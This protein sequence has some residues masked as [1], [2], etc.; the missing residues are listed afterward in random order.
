M[1]AALPAQAIA[2]LDSTY[3][4]WSMVDNFAVL[5][6]PGLQLSKLDTS[7]CYPNLV[8]GDFDGDGRIDYAAYVQYNSESQGRITGIVA[9]LKRG[10][11]YE[12]HLLQ[13]GSDFIWLA[14][15]G[16]RRYDFETGKYFIL[17]NDAIDDIF[18]EKAAATFVF[19]NGRFKEI[20]T[21]D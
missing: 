21:S 3:P 19:Q 11:S 18:I 8:W 10:Q 1:K 14:K 12:P 7:E 13:G 16:S 6:D 4:A 9:L 17:G 15:K 20:T 2:V 5:E